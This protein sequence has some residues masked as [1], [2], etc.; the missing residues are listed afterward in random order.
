MISLA[1]CLVLRPIPVR[2]PNMRRAI[3]DDASPAL[4][5]VNAMMTRF[6]SALSKN[7]AEDDEAE[8]L[9][10]LEDTRPELLHNH[11]PV[12]WSWVGRISTNT[13]RCIVS[14]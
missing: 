14:S 5:S 11:D 2:K 9:K 13:G 10:L 8:L 12:I 1:N 4:D 7:P 6:Y 3:M